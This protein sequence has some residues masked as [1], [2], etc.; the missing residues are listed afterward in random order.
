[1]IITIII[2]LILIRWF[3]DGAGYGGKGGRRGRR[4]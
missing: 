2:C 4:R 3:L 1:M